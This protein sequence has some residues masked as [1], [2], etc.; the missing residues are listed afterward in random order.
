MNWQS[1][2]GKRLIKNA[3]DDPQFFNF[4]VYPQSAKRNGLTVFS[5]IGDVQYGSIEA[6]KR[7]PCED[8]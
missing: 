8:L 2:C 6:E 5:Y 7:D 3:V 1:L 4:M